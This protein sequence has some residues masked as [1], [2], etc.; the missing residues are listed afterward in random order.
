MSTSNIPC[1]ISLVI[2]ER[3]MLNHGAR[4]SSS[5]RI[6]SFVD[7]SLTW[8]SVY[9]QILPPHAQHVFPQRNTNFLE[10]LPI[11]ANIRPRWNQYVPSSS[12][13]LSRLMARNRGSTTSPT[14]AP[15][16]VPLRRSSRTG[17]GAGGRD[18][19]LDQ[20]ADILVAP[21]RQQKRSFAPDD[22]DS[23]PVNPHAP[24]PKKR[25]TRRKNVRLYAG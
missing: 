4:L 17:R 9:F 25:R 23:L 6:R 16:P 10:V 22:L 19:Q 20:L 5:S 12:V 13:L 8:F 14:P 24:A 15:A 7:G 2:P 21:T 3:Y 11:L 18:V 1:P